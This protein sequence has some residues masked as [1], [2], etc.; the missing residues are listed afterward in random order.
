MAD[1][2]L[3][4]VLV[5]GFSKRIP[6][7][8][9][10]K[11]ERLLF[12]FTALLKAFALSNMAKRSSEVKSFTVKIDLVISYLPSVKSGLMPENATSE[13]PFFHQHTFKKTDLMKTGPFSNRKS[14]G[15]TVLHHPS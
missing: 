12:S 4:R 11:T 15:V 9:F 3:V 2:K 5:D 13:F 14:P 7:T 1:S 10:F 8:E 6:M